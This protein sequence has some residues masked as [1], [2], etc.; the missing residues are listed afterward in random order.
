MDQTSRNTRHPGARFLSPGLAPAIAFSFRRR[1]RRLDRIFPGVAPRR[2]CDGPE[3]F[4]LSRPP[5]ANA[6]RSSGLGIA[7]FVFFNNCGAGEMAGIPSQSGFI[8]AAAELADR[9]RM[10]SR[11]RF[12]SAITVHSGTLRHYCDSLSSD[13]RTNRLLGV[14]ILFMVVALLVFF[15][16]LV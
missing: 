2:E 15:A 3:R 12:A 13:S 5:F 9:S 4:R 10:F 6:R 11:A 7:G 8:F 16:S 14:P 1:S